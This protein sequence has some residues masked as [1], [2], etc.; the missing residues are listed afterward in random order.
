MLER[1]PIREAAKGSVIHAD[2]RG[3]RDA[4]EPAPVADSRVPAGSPRLPNFLII[5]AMKAGTSLYHYVRAHPQV[6]VPAIKEIDFFVAAANRARGIDGYGRQ[7]T[8]AGPDVVAVGEVPTN[9]TKYPSVGGVP[10]RLVDHLP[11]VRLLHV[12]CDPIERI[13][14][15]YRLRFELEQLLKDDMRRQR[16]RMTKGFGGWG[17]A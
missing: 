16:V 9:Y 12:V 7:C 13:R 5:G 10:E 15:H 14:S 1:S 17:L 2:D 4:S 11:G 3:E 6:F 8:G